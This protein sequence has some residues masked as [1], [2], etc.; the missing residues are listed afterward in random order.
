MKI[1]MMSS[2]FADPVKEIEFAGDH[3]F[4]GLELAFEQPEATP[5]QILSKSKQILDAFSRYDLIRISHTQ[6]FVNICDFSEAVRRAS[7]DETI[8]ALEAAHRLG[9]GFLTVHPG[10]MWPMM[11]REKALEKTCESLRELLKVADK[12]DLAL[13]VENLPPLF[14]PPRG[15]FIK[16]DDFEVLFSQIMSDRLKF[17]LDIA[18]AGFRESDPA[19]KFIS[20]FYEKL[21]HVHLSDNFGQR[22]DHLPLGAGRVD[23]KTPVEALKKRGYK[24]TVTLEIFSQDRDYLLISKRKLEELLR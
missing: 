8:K 2:L 14:S 3:G 17:V 20:K 23:Y 9:I 16:I 10:F 22:D 12:L 1:C 24:G 19:P 5:E 21:G 7:L 13:G 15:Y 11:T 4:Q 18:H 6:S